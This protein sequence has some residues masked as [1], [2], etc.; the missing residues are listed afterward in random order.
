MSE[1]KEIL[2]TGAS[3]FIASH[4][5]IQLLN[6]GYRVR[7]T[8]RNLSRADKLKEVIGKHAPT[9]GL[10][11]V[12]AD[13]M[14]ADSWQAAVKGTDGIM[15]VASPIATELP[16]DP[17]EMIVPAKE[18]TRNVLQA[19]IDQGV[20][21][22]VIT[23]SVASIVYG[24]GPGL[25]T[26]DNWTNT[27]HRDATPYIQSKTIAEKL[28]W[29]M[30]QEA[31]DKLQ[32]TTVH[33]SLVLGP[34]LEQDYGNSA[35][36]VKKLMDGSFPGTPNLGLPIV[37]VRDVAS[38]HI[39]AFENDASIGER[40]ICSGPFL[41]MHEIA[42]ILRKHYPDFQKKIPTRKLPTWLVKLF[43][44]FQKE[45]KSVLQDVDV[46]RE[47]TWEKGKRILGWDPRGPEEAIRATADSLIEFKIL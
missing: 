29:E 19:A 13:L 16:K 5:V 4:I 21:R 30:A 36:V 6:Q 7:G 1:G 15:H 35:E 8:V 40:L 26:E 43:A 23:S 2:V 45:V 11:F 34:V 38:M 24:Q 47:V 27:D 37:D 44:N 10:S 42:L 41:W 20:P 31:G 22:V 9:T 33:P 39:M 46:R 28:A 18:G 14:D 25:F 3:G 12:Q 32:I 17:N